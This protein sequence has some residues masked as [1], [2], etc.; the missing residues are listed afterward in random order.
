MADN[1]ILS[2]RT[3]RKSFFT[4][5]NRL[6]VIHQLDLDINPGQIVAIMGESGSGKST[7]L[8]MLGSLELPDSGQVIFKGKS[9]GEMSDN[10]RAELRNRQFGFVFQNFNLIPGLTAAE[11]IE[12][13]LIYS[14]VEKN[15]RHHKAMIALKIVGLEDRADHTPA[16]LS[17]GQQ[18]RVALARALVNNPQIL[19]ADEPTGSLDELSAEHVMQLLVNL[20]QAGKAIVMVTHDKKVAAKADLV[21]QLSEGTLSRVIV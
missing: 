3:L 10:D 15:Q 18:Q 2:T 5:G 6:E 14:G 13:P 20:K 9:L 11:N 12:L 19:F 16:Q 1:T 4:G 8:G 17:G 21:F 7:L